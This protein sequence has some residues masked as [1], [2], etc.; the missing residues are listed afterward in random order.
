MIE[1]AHKGFS[2]IEL[3]IV[4]FILGILTSLIAGNFLTS[5]KKGRDA[6]RKADLQE[7]QKALEMYYENNK[8]YPTDLSFGLPLSDGSK[9]Y[10]QKI[11]KDPKSPTCEY[12]YVTDVTRSYYYLLATIE[13]TQDQSYGVS[14]TGYK[15]PNNP[16]SKL[17]CGNC[18]CKFYVSSPN[19]EVLNSF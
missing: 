18:D 15:D 17:K 3:M 13:N 14:Q 9:T 8:K 7:I 19:S 4:I 5:L 6:R 12:K 2:L 1:K 16:G 11:P 10:M